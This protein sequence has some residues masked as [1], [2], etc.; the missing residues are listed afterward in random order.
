M[1]YRGEKWKEDSS[2]TP[3][4]TMYPKKSN[5]FLCKKESKGNNLIIN[6]AS[7]FLRI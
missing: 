3:T 7:I 5:K 2:L 1:L 4:S 6:M